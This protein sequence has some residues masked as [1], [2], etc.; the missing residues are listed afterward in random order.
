MN[1]LELFFLN[2]S[3]TE[4]FKTVQNKQ[5]Q[6]IPSVEHRKCICS[7]VDRVV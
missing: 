5:N 6:F 7:T 3:V 2:L 1:T 4:D